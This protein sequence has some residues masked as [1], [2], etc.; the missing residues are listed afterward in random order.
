MVRTEKQILQE[1]FLTGILDMKMAYFPTTNIL[2]IEEDGLV[3][4]I[5][6]DHTGY[7]NVEDYTI[8]QIDGPLKG[9]NVL[10]LSLICN[11]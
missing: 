3:L 11:T 10:I 4:T 6:L 2:V 8:Q 7:Y 1:L 9:P 5:K